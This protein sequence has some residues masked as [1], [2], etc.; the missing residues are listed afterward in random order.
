MLAAVNAKYIHSNLAVYSLKACAA[1][2]GYPTEIR[3]YT[4]NQPFGD[5]LK[6]LYQS[7][8]D[9]LGFSC[10]IW[11]KTWIDD[12]AR[13][14]RKLLP[15]I[16]IWVGGP[17]VTYCAQEYLKRH[18]A[19]NGIMRGEGEG[20]FLA[21]ARHFR[22]DAPD[23]RLEAIPGL[24][25]RR[26]GS[27]RENP[28]REPLCMDELPFPYACLQD[29]ENRIIYY[30]SSRGCPFSCSYCLSS[31]D[32]KLRFRSLELVKKEMQF[33]IDQKV[34]Q[35]KF[36]DRTFNCDRARALEI[37]RFLV[38]KD[39]GVTNFHFEIGADLL[40]PEEIDCM[41]SMRPGLI[42][43]EIGVQSTNPDTIREIRRKTDFEKIKRNVAQIRQGQNIHQHLDLIAGLPYEGY[44]SFSRS[45]DQVYA[46][47]PQQL[48]LGFLKALKGSRMERMAPEYGLVYMD[49]EPYE[50]LKTN[51]LS[52][53]ELLALKQVEAM[54]EIYYNSG[55]FQHTLPLLE[56]LFPSPFEFYQKL[57]AFYEEKGYSQIS[58]S[59]LRRYD[60]LLEFL[61]T[62]GFAQ[63]D[64]SE[65]LLES[66]QEAM[67]IDL[68]CRENLKSRPA[69]MKPQEPW[70]KAVR[71]YI[72]RDGLPKTVHI[73]ILSRETLLFDYRRRDPLTN[74]VEAKQIIL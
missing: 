52:Y 9:F 57:G 23:A 49:R 47:R 31:L 39:Q 46:M 7:R 15:E 11:N 20:S 16:Q 42:Q 13:E 55:Q 35:V 59:R 22:E 3:E 68:Y 61:K 54:V 4:I 40:G 63:A 21:L 6:D 27:I 56:N 69:W 25:F 1:Q 34:P 51:W 38:E 73:E 44:A 58:H 18:P 36:V 30:E 62:G 24:T 60:I 37:W 5:I 28:D 67:A 43:L 70:Q 50:V 32:R 14:I 29:F 12:L 74:N 19:V 2:A 10:Y 65:T 64:A 53:E 33:F 71:D 41:K 66:V 45:F 72:R 48:Q 26:D 17:E 8:P